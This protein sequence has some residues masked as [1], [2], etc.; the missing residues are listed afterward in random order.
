[1]TIT[2]AVC[3]SRDWISCD[4]GTSETATRFLGGRIA[5][6]QPAAERPV[7]A[8]CLEHWQQALV[9]VPAR[10]DDAS[11]DDLFDY[12]RVADAKIALAASTEIEAAR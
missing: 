1:M 2:C 11:D 6:I 9:R 3:G 5:E 8:W 7:R 12:L 10:S 4:P